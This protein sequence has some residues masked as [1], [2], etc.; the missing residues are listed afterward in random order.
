MAK[1]KNFP[2]P[3]YLTPRVV[4]IFRARFLAKIRINFFSNVYVFASQNIIDKS[5]PYKIGEYNGICVSDS[6]K[7]EKDDFS[8]F[9]ISD[10]DYRKALE[11]IYSDE[12][13]FFIQR[14]NKRQTLKDEKRKKVTADVYIVK[15]SDFNEYYSDRTR[16]IEKHYQPHY[17]DNLFEEMSKK[18]KDTLF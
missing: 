11:G 4:E 18:P 1:R 6:W 3:L 7:E 17:I 12:L 13:L 16:F 2:K 10:E 9:I 8:V 14:I 5:L 15:E